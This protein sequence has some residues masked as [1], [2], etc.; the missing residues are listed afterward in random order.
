MAVVVDT[1]VFSAPLLIRPTMG[2]TLEQQYA[3]HLDGHQPVIAA[4]TLAELHF[5]A[6]IGRWGRRR[7][8]RL[9]EL[10]R[11]ALLAVPDEP[12]CERFGT[13]KARL[14]RGG[15]PLHQER[16]TADLWIATTACHLGL[17]LVAH[18]RIFVGCPGLD[19]R[20]EL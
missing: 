18:D 3:P 15:H 14:R 9:D 4:H 16:H 5:G 17:P 7:R 10:A 8:T 1:G 12:M 13:L 6:E 20:T 19:L 2:K 11:S